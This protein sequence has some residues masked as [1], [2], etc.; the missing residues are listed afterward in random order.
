M[1]SLP[2]LALAPRGGGVM[3]VMPLVVLLAVT[4]VLARLVRL[5][6]CGAALRAGRRRSLTG[7]RERT[8]QQHHSNRGRE[9]FHHHVPPPTI[10]AGVMPRVSPI[11]SR[12]DALAR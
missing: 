4:R 12:R 7:E 6:L 5:R 3:P 8:D 9:L 2:F 1:R 10:S 11:F